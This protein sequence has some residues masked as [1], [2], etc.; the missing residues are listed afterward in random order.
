MFTRRSTLLA[1]A[2]FAAGRG[3]RTARAASRTLELWSYEQP[4]DANVV[5]KAI[6]YIVTSFEQANPGTEVKVTSMPWQQLSP[7]LLRASH[8]RRVPD[9]AM[10]YSPDMP[11]QIAAHTLL[12]LNDRLAGW[13][14]EQRAD[15]VRLRQAED[16]QGTVYGLP[17]QQRTSGLIYRADLLAKAGQ[18]PPRTLQEWS[19]TAAAVQGGDVVGVAMGFSP[20]G[21]S[22][23]AGWFLAT[24]L[25]LGAA[26]LKPDGSAMFNTPQALRAVAWVLE[27]VKRSPPTLPMDVAMQD[28]EKEHDLFSARRAVFLPTSSDR[29]AR[30]VAQSGLSFEAI[31]MTGYPTD[32]AARPVPALVQSWNLAIPAGARQPDLGWQFI[33]HWLSA[34]VQVQSSR[35]AGFGPVRRS[36]L[37]DP[38]FVEPRAQVMRWGT[39]YAIAHPMSFNFP[40]NTSMLYDVWGRMF[41][42][43][44]AGE[45]DPQGGLQWANAE[46]DQRNRG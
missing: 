3:A 8:A 42:R 44:L 16:A 32:D 4:G 45:L 18:Q 23:A 10:F 46:F 39:E 34:P 31:G 7:T 15:L 26:V 35:I 9:V 28:Q 13:T 30:E 37:S 11:V 33:E 12:P 2:A 38:F 40:T 19:D 36:A 17:W 29:H 22:V 24:Q 27:Q 21:I 5:Q 43:V 1:G 25:G 20:A 6:A 41:G 14:P